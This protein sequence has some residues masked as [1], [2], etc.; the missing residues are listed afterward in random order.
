LGDI[1]VNLGEI[2]TDLIR[3]GQYKNIASSKKCNFLRL[4]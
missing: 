4:C 1:W 2:W 3:F